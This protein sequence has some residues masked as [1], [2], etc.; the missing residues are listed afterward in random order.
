M[1]VSAFEALLGL[2]WLGCAATTEGLDCCCLVG[3]GLP[4][5]APGGL[6]ADA[7]KRRLLAGRSTDSDTAGRCGGSLILGDKTT[8]DGST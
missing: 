3:A 5:T 7:S 6:F 8:P 4:E 1:C 2:T